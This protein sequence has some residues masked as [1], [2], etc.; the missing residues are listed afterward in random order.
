MKKF[1]EPM[2]NVIKFKTETILTLS[3]YSSSGGDDN[4]YVNE[5]NYREETGPWM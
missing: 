3:A 5:D 1:E 2:V 4:S